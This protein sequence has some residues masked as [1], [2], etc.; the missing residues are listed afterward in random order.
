MDISDDKMNVYKDLARKCESFELFKWIVGD[1]ESWMTEAGKAETETMLKT[2]Y[3]G[4]HIT[5]RQ[6]LFVDMDGTLAEFKTVDTLETLYEKDYF[7]NL[8]PN[9]NVLGAI[10]QLIADNDIDVYILSAYLTDSRYALEEK[11]AWL[12]KYLPELPQEKRLFVP[13][14]TDKSV[15]VPGLIRP[16]DYLLDDYTKNL[17]E[18][19]PPARGIKLINGINH[20]NGTWQ[21]DKIQFTHAPEELS[22]MI[23]DVMK[24]WTHFY[25]DRIVTDSVTMHSTKNDNRGEYDI[26][27]TEVLQKVVSTKAASLQEAIQ[28]VEEQ[29]HNSEIILDAED[30]KETTI[31]AAH[32]QLDEEIT[33]DLRGIFL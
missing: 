18:W 6:R 2:I 22:S 9:E 28:D 23:S 20:T 32:P 5:D 7:I 16:D 12:D 27:I 3:N 10:K 25:E 17:S 19:E 15:A 1:K 13:C 31:E 24:G 21:G 29:Y 8:K 26:E 33:T 30:L 4:V 14:G 11:N